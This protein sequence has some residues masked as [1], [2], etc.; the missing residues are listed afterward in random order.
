[1][2]PD[3]VTAVKEKKFIEIILTLKINVNGSRCYTRCLSNVTDRRAMIAL[4]AEH[5]CRR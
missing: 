3:I 4:L 1:M 5:L 2:L